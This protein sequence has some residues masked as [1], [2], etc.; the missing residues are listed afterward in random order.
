MDAGEGF[1]YLTSIMDLYSRKIISW[2]LSRTMEVKDVL[3]CLEKAKE[4]KYGKT[5]CHPQWT[6][7]S[8]FQNGIRIDGRNKAQL[9]AKG[10]CM[11]R[12]ASNHFV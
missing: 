9:F 1:V 7:C 10:N 3:E 5:H 2:K 11:G 4:E 6:E 8:W 12:H